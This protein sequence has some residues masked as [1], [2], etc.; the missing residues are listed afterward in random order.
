MNPATTRA[1]RDY[2]LKTAREM[3][4]HR[5]EHAGDP[6]PSFCVGRALQFHR[7]LMRTLKNQPCS[8]SAKS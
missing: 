3:K 8:P 7:S 1:A 6:S 4:I 5:D 2:W